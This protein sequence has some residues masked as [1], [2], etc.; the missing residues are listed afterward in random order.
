MTPQRRMYLMWLK[1]KA[2]HRPGDPRSPELLVAWR[3][4][5]S[6]REVTAAIEAERNKP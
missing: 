1:E 6:V 3:Y 4:D 2:R 5:V